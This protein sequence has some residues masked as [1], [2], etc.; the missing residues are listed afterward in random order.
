MNKN[1]ILIYFLIL[2]VLALTAASSWAV[3]LSLEQNRQTLANGPVDPAAGFDFVVIG[4]SRGGG[5]V[6][7]RLLAR[8]AE[9]HPLFI[10]HTGDFTD[11]G[12]AAE[13]ESYAQQIAAFPIPML[14]LPGNHDMGNPAVYAHYVGSPNWFMDLGAIRLI[15]LDNTGGKFTPEALFTAREALTDHKICLVAF[16]VPPAMGHWSVHAMARDEQGASAREVL[17]LIKKARVPL[18]LLG[19][20]HLHDEMEING[21]QYIIS[22]GG[23]ARLHKIYNFGRA[24]Y[25][26]LLV[27]VRPQGITHRWIPLK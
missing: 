1:R 3:P 5:E 17:D 19:H 8:A 2:P 24:E 25:G 16:H 26:F 9:M 4:D 21:T 10:L 15:G 13:F 6:F 18:V 12:T 20:I 7:S 27:L 14:H 11:K 22:A 23:G